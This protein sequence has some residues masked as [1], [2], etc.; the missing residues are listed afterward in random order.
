MDFTGTS[1]NDI[2][3]GTADDD[4]IYGL[5][6]NDTLNGKG[7]EDYIIGGAGNDTLDGGGYVDDDMY[8]TLSYAEE[9]IYMGGTAGVTVNLLT[10]KAKDTFG[11]TD[12]FSDF[13]IIRGTQFDDTF[14]GGTQ[15][16]VRW[17]GLAGDDL[18]QG[19][20]NGY[21]TVSYRKDANYVDE[22]GNYG[23]SGVYVDLV[24]GTATDGYG[25]TD[26]LVSI[27]QIR[28]SDY[29]DTLLGSIDGERLRGEEG[30][31]LINGRGGDDRLEGDEGNDTIYGGLGNDWISGNTG[32]DTIY[33]GAGNDDVEG[34]EGDDYI[35]LGVGDN[36]AVGG[37][38]NDTMIGSDDV[39]GWD[40]IY[41]EYDYDLG[42]TSGITANFQTGKVIDGF[43]DTDT[44]VNIN[45]IRGTRVADTFIG[46][47]SASDYARFQGLA[48]NDTFIGG[49]G[50]DALDYRKDQHIM[51]VSG[52]YGTSGVVVDLRAG[53]ATDGYGD[54]DTLSGIE[55]V[56][57]SDYRDRLFGSASSDRLRGEGGND[58]LDGR[59]GADD[60]EGDAGNDTYIVDNL[61]DTVEEY[62]GEGTDLV[63]SSVRFSLKAQSQYIENL[64][65]TG[66]AAI[67]GTGNGLGNVIRGNSA[68]N[69]LNGL[70]G[71]DT[72]MGL[73]GNDTLYGGVGND[74]LFGNLGNDRLFGG[75]GNDLLDGGIGSDVM[76]GNKGNDTYVVDNLNDK[77]NE[78][79]GQ[80][81][82]LVKSSVSFSLKDHSGYLENLTL[83]GIAANDGTGNAL[84]NI[85]KGN[86]AANGLSGLNGNDKLYGYGGADTLRGG[87]GN[88]LLA[89]GN[90]NDALFGEN[91]NDT[92]FG[93]LGADKLY[94]ATGADRFVGGYGRDLMFAGVD[95]AVDTFVFNSAD[96]SKVGAAHDVI[97]LFES[98]E[99]KLDVS[100]IDADASAAGDQAFVF[101]GTSATANS[102]WYKTVNA[103]VLVYGDTDGDAAADFAI[104]LRNVAS[105]TESD[106]VL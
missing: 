59:G 33:A 56:R 74:R 46:T 29:A 49:I 70:F 9:I 91:G 62:A 82:D 99:D 34:G 21:E 90:G 94:G 60:L 98:G 67:N 68:A 8:D 93:N 50:W 32:N 96:E 45:S 87:N 95:N 38:G 81:I 79:A 104:E 24:A 20:V 61:G 13:E 97:Y 106:F 64:T 15:S 16:Y 11:D 89:G 12:S 17:I 3:N 22:N 27:E 76:S 100:G 105:L 36:A 88:D 77:V 52:K 25:D 72:L 44:I 71:N 80:G 103:N 78:F 4:D 48:G 41:Y 35:D 65:L 26:T 54:T 40:Q 14:I 101:A 30:D 57:G 31:D 83:I 10:G 47:A 92:L 19:S 102:V 84:A 69:V 1:G 51:D 7:G 55:E 39:D 63:K 23:T 18:F 42:G 66:S 75:T 43:G 58:L 53:T 2:I 86:V 5:A 37:A 85:L 6:G 73:G 28:G